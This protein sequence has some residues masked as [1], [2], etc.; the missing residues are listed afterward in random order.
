MV[1]SKNFAPR[2]HSAE[3]F[4]R[5]E[6]LDLTKYLNKNLKLTFPNYDTG[7]EKEIKV[8]LVGISKNSSTLYDENNCYVTEKVLKNIFQNQYNEFGELEDWKITKVGISKYDANH[9][10]CLWLLWPNDF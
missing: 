8:K 4:N 2:D 5:F 7:E 9:W 3:E 1:C 6:M 10:N